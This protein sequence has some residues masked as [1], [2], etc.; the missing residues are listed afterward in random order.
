MAKLD[1]LGPG[2]DAA[3]AFVRDEI[4]YEVYAGSLRGARGALW[5]GAGNSVDQASLLIALLR[6]QGIAARY[7]RGTLADADAQEL[8][9]S[10]FDPELAEQA[11]GYVPED[12]D[13]A[14][15]ENDA[16]LLA[17]AR[18]HWWVELED[19]TEIDPCFTDGAPRA[20]PTETHFEIPD[21]MRHKVTLRLVAEFQVALFSLQEE[22]VPLDRT[23]ASAELCGRPPVLAFNVSADQSPTLIGALGIKQFNYVPYLV[24][25]DG[26]DD[27]SNDER[28]S[29]DPF[30]EM[31]GFLNL[32]NTTLTRLRLEIET[33]GPDS[34]VLVHS[35]DIL[36]RIGFG[37]R[38]GLG[39]PAAVSAEDPALNELQCIAIHIVCGGLDPA[40]LDVRAVAREALAAEAE[41]LFERM[42]P[43]DAIPSD[44]WTEEQGATVAEG[45][46]QIHRG[47]RLDAR[48]LGEKFL[49][50]SAAKGKDLAD[51]FLVRAY[52]DHPLVVLCDA[53]PDPETDSMQFGLDLRHDTLRAVAYP[54]QSEAAPGLFA[55]Q[56][57]FEENLVE[58]GVM[59]GLRLLLGAELAGPRVLSTVTVFEEAETQDI[60]IV[61]LSG[62]GDIPTIEHMDLSGDAKA[63]ILLALAD[64][65]SV[66]VPERM[67]EVDGAPEIGWFRIDTETGESIG[68]MES[69]RHQAM[70][71]YGLVVYLSSW[72]AL[73]TL[74]SIH[75][76]YLKTFVP[77]LR[78]TQEYIQQLQ[79]EAYRRKEESYLG[80]LQQVALNAQSMGQIATV[81]YGGSSDF[82]DRK[83]QAGLDRLD[84]HQAVNF[85]ERDEF[86]KPILDEDGKPILYSPEIGY[87]N[88]RSTLQDKRD[89]ILEFIDKIEEI[90][91]ET[92]DSYNGSRYLIE[93]LEELPW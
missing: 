91:A 7:V 57:G 90:A 51:T 14:D 85:Y 39:D 88:W 58:R 43:L 12:Y 28:V 62:P 55:L 71:D 13:I 70:I 83:I 84:E 45:V 53:G 36:D 60:P 92:K 1:E 68:V 61:L 24:M 52:P 9:R 76:W 18:D 41:P 4:A 11:V 69:G 54:G 67:V 8:V 81:S 64:G 21:A 5:S 29:G 31:F 63:R 10:M 15:P 48:I 25:D 44:Q 23:F 17:E 82:L 89:N 34:G 16:D 35:R 46:D 74:I 22:E 78:A 37:A 80:D 30:T 75:Q 42:L 47:L 56:R 20:L 87:L 65:D 3:A 2:L 73:Y 59:E 19:G 6:A 33:T 72:A 86:G 27:P 49:L 32:V 26:D 66:N 77:W 79:E 40:I 38:H 93:D 50:R